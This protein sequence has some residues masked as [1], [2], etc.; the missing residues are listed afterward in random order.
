MTLLLNYSKP[1]L[2]KIKKIWDRLFRKQFVISF[3]L[4][5]IN[6]IKIFSHKETFEEFMKMFKND[7]I[8]RIGK[9][10]YKWSEVI[11][12]I[13][14]RLI[15]MYDDY[16]KEEENKGVS[17]PIDII[18]QL[19]IKMKEEWQKPEIKKTKWKKAWQ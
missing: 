7:Y 8:E 17:A 5:E 4:S 18:T 9:K 14:E 1:M 15:N 19:Q 16:Y 12:D 3:S 10:D 11:R 6:E 2:L 13:I